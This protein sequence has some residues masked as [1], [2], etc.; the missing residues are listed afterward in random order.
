MN[1]PTSATSNYGWALWHLEMAERDLGLA[2]CAIHATAAQTRATLAL[3][4]AQN[5]DGFAGST[6]SNGADS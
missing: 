4:D 2:M 3:V 5:G 1:R 6:W